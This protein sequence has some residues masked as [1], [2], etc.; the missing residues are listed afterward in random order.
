MYFTERIQNTLM[1]P[2]IITMMGKTD[3]EKHQQELKQKEEKI[4][5]LSYQERMELK[6]REHEERKRQKFEKLTIEQKAEVTNDP[7]LK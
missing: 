1:R 2:E 3:D 6:Q 4:Q 7:E 5:A